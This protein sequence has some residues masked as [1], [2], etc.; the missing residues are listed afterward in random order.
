[1]RLDPFSFPGV[2]S[3]LFCSALLWYCTTLSFFLFVSNDYAEC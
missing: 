2:S 1:M 3:V